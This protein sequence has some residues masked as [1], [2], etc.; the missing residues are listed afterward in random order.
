MYHSC[1]IA[2]PASPKALRKVGWD[3]C[4]CGDSS[5]DFLNKCHKIHLQ[6]LAGTQERLGSY[7]KI[8]PP[9]FRK[10]LNDLSEA[11]GSGKWCKTPRRITRSNAF[12]CR[13]SSNADAT[14]KWG[15]ES[16]PRAASINSNSVSKSTRTVAGGRALNSAG[17]VSD[18]RSVIR[19]QGPVIGGLFDAG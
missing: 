17:K 13:D 16:M 14:L 5:I 1:S 6:I 19:G 2:N 15:R 12:A 8:R 11:C 7:N 4:P 10:N 18:Q 3:S 9:G